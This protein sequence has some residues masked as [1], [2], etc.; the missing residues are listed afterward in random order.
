LWGARLDQHLGRGL[1]NWCR[2]TF[3]YR[4][5]E[6]NTSRI[7]SEDWKSF[8]AELRRKRPQFL[9]AYSQ[10]AVLFAHY[11]RERAIEDIQF[12]SIITT[13]EVL[14]P[15]QR[16]LLER[17][18][19]GRVFN[20]YGCREVSVIAS[21][22]ECHQGMHVNAE[23]LLLEVIPDPSIPS[24][25]GRIVITDLL[26]FSMPLIRYEI[27]D[28]GAWAE[29]PCSCG[30]SL[31]LLADV[32]GRITDFLTLP[33]GCR[34]SGPA[35]TLV[36]ADMA[37]VRQVQF[38]QESPKSVVLRVVPGRDYGAHTDEELRRRLAF[39]LGNT[40]TLSIEKVEHIAREVSGKY[41]FVINEAPPEVAVCGPAI[42][43]RGRSR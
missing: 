36:V 28:I 33:D 24:P 18:F 38:V 43:A 13:A 15:G 42:A 20:R 39:Y 14:L 11:L 9:I 4:T 7:T 17:T 21:E 19:H 5:V 25:G 10:S 23:A 37:D 30:R 22:C 3:L 16:E 12:Q 34:I 2:N 27:G 1:W 41:R 8:V 6:L 35:L 40:M 31:P 32:Q 26:N 29:L